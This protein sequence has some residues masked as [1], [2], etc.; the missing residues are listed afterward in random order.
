MAVYFLWLFCFSKTILN[1]CVVLLL[2][3]FQWLQ[4]ARVVVQNIF[5]WVRKWS[6]DRRCIWLLVV[7]VVF[8][9]FVFFFKTFF[10]LVITPISVSLLNLTCVSTMHLRCNEGVKYSGFQWLIF[11]CGDC[12]ILKRKLRGKIPIQGTSDL[13]LLKWEWKHFLITGTGFF[14]PLEG[15]N[16]IFQ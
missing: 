6:F 3:Y 9:C 8:L 7:C 5:S 15:I 12:Q 1:R 11:S 16:G 2:L 4:W 13:Q 10:Y 14:N